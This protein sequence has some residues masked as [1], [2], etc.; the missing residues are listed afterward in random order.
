MAAVR[1][2]G[3]EYIDAVSPVW[4]F[5]IV[6]SFRLALFSSCR[7]RRRLCFFFSRV[8]FPCSKAQNANNSSRRVSLAEKKKEAAWSQTFIA[9]ISTKCCIHALRQRRR[10]S[11]RAPC[12]STQRLHKGVKSHSSNYKKTQA[13]KKIWRS[14]MCFSS[15]AFKIF[16]SNTRVTWLCCQY[17]RRCVQVVVWTV[18]CHWLTQKT[19][20]C[21]FVWL[22]NDTNEANSFNSLNSF[23]VLMW[24]LDSCHATRRHTYHQYFYGLRDVNI[25]QDKCTFIL[26]YPFI[27]FLER[28]SEGV[29]P[30]WQ[31]A[32]GVQT[33]TRVRVISRRLWASIPC[34]C[35]HSEIHAFFF[36]FYFF[37]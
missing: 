33:D 6:P 30:H 18:V 21:F 35:F 9:T 19:Q 26:F 12:F 20:L 16:S 23:S 11:N 3:A 29:T 10:R 37:T 28:M 5:F 24:S 27:L 17:V 4:L 25:S 34:G 1:G 36:F 15:V 8:Y 7:R 31:E 14:Y 32:G 13:P 2:H 22:Q